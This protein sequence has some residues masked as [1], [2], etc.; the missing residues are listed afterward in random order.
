[1]RPTDPD[2]PTHKK[3]DHTRGCALCDTYVLES[4][5]KNGNCPDCE[6]KRRAF[7]VD[8]LKL[9]QYHGLHVTSCQCCSDRVEPCGDPD[10]KVAQLEES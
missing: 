4:V 8:Y 6:T 1:M 5:M 2:W 7:L 3:T 10:A 9:I